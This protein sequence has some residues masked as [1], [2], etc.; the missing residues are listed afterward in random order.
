MRG[1]GFGANVIAQIAKNHGETEEEVRR[2]IEKAIMIAYKEKGNGSK[3]SEIF[4]KNV[5]PT[6]EEFIEKVGYEVKGRL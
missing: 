3:W 6:P 1:K 4:G 5:I 2:E